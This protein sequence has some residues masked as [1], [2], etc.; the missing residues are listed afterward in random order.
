MEGFEV[1]RSFAAFIIYNMPINFHEVNPQRVH[2][3]YSKLPRIPLENL[4]T[5]ISNVKLSNAAL[6]DALYS[7]SVENA[8]FRNAIVTARVLYD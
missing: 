6:R 7:I 4:I 8:N 1:E 3:L 2:E 5:P